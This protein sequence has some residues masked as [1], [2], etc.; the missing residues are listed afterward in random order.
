MGTEPE[1][2]QLLSQYLPLA[3]GKKYRLIWR[4]RSENHVKGQGLRW[5]ILKIKPGF[6]DPLSANLTGPDLAQEDGDKAGW[7]F[8]AP[9]D[10]DLFLLSLDYSRPLG[11]TRIE[12]NFSIGDM[13]IERE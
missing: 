6:S 1:N 8:T 12:G 3:P 10:T 2:C 11:M 4:F 13:A 9:L 7:K 5:R